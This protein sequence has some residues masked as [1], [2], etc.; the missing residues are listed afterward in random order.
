MEQANVEIRLL[1][2]QIQKEVDDFETLRDTLQARE[3]TIGQ[4]VAKEY[5]LQQD[6]KIARMEQQRLKDMVKVRDARIEELTPEM[7]D[8]WCDARPLDDSRAVQLRD[9]ALLVKD[10][11]IADLSQQNLK[12]CAWL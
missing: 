3:D 6:L 2:Q 11:Q 1:E 4:A 8:G 5:N 7:V 10:K 9:D 12:V